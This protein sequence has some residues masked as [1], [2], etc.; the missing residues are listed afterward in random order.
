[1]NL[2]I[3]QYKTMICAGLSSDMLVMHALKHNC[4]NKIFLKCSCQT[5]SLLVVLE[6][7]AFFS[8]LF[9]QILSLVLKS[10]LH[11]SLMHFLSLIIIRSNSF[12]NLREIIEAMA[13][14]DF[15]VIPNFSSFNKNILLFNIINVISTFENKVDN[16]ATN[17]F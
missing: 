1:M 9:R 12:I 6:S 11:Q 10:M 7:N 13:T 17:Y 14:W 15:Y 4:L 2:S 8:Y 16:L 5:D 3:F